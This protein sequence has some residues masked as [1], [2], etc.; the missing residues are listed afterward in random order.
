MMICLGFNQL[1]RLIGFLHVAQGNFTK[2][3]KTF[4]FCTT[5]GANRL[6][7]SFGEAIGKV[8]TFAIPKGC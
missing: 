1:N 2:K 8:K 5:S 7:N 4:T 3:D 6:R